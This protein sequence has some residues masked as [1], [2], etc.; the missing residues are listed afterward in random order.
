MSF[1]GV[2]ALL[3]LALCVL[4]VGCATPPA[5]LAAAAGNTRDLRLVT[6]TVVPQLPAAMQADWTENLITFTVRAEALEA[7]LKGERFDQHAA[8]A[9]EAQRTLDA[10]K[11]VPGG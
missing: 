11:G 10:R 4:A 1:R 3:A 6:D 2:S 8:E 5:I 9:A 7:Y